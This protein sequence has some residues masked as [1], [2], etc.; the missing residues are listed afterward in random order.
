MQSS[1]RYR[2]ISSLFTDFKTPMCTLPMV[3]RSPAFLYTDF[4]IHTDLFSDFVSKSVHSTIFLDILAVSCHAYSKTCL[5]LDSF[6]QGCPRLIFRLY[7]LQAQFRLLRQI[8][9]LFRQS[10]LRIHCLLDV[11][12]EHNGLCHSAQDFPK[13]MRFV[14]FDRQFLA[15][16]QQSLLLFYSNMSFPSRLRVNVHSLRWFSLIKHHRPT[17]LLDI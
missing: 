14:L 16:R 6:Q 17:C 7:L 13:P 8:R 2:K 9:R 15:F 10:I 5:R 4:Y 11:L 12:Y 3:P 1:V